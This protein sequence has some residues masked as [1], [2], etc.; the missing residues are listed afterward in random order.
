MIRQ[1]FYVSLMILG[2][3]GLLGPAATHA[4]RVDHPTCTGAELD[5]ATTAYVEAQRTGDISK[6]DFADTAEYLE[7]MKQIGKTLEHR[8][9][10]R[11]DRQLP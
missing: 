3:A 10:N 4:Q 1:I 11:L 9:A 8:A 7:N 2:A 5:A 6:L